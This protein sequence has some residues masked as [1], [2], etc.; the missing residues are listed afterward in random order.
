MRPVAL[1]TI[2]ASTTILCGC[3]GTVAGISLSSI[4]SFAGF[5]STLF[6]GADLGE[7]AVSLVTG[8]DC[9]FS[10][11]LV[12]AD[13]DICEE[14]GSAATRDDFHGI[15][16]ERIDA[17]GTIVYAAPKFMPASVGAGENEN[18]PDQIW[19]EIKAAKAL[20]E[21]ERQLAR[22]NA[23]QQIDV[24]ALTTNTVS[25]ESLAFLPASVGSA[26]AIDGDTASQTAQRPRGVVNASA[27]TPAKPATEAHVAPVDADQPAIDATTF[28]SAVPTTTGEGGPLLPTSM[29]SAPVASKLINGQPVVI[30]RLRPAM[31]AA[32]TTPFDTATA[33]PSLPIEDTTAVTPPPAKV[34]AR[35]SSVRTPQAIL[36]DAPAARPTLPATTPTRV[37]QFETQPMP[38]TAAPSKPKTKPAVTEVAAAAPASAKPAALAPAPRKPAPTEAYVPDADAAYVGPTPI[39]VPADVP[40][41]PA[42]AHSEPASAAA[43]TSDPSEPAPSPLLPMQ[44]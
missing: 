25:S 30:L 39:Q 4:S 27:K 5:A 9:R 32:V 38:A 12:R 10:E 36:S 24:A 1:A 26:D 13:R 21:S 41:E 29:G 35:P 15:F 43:L 42:P 40:A 18:D 19:A 23:A 31:T 6:T 20:E 22:A 11:G 7:H 34:A 17:D 3:A 37:A 2:L 16:V 28:A 8:K 14:R 44:Q 33:L